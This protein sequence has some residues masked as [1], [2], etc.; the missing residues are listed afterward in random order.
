MVML[1]KD[2]DFKKIE[3]RWQAF[4]DQNKT[5]RAVDNSNQPTFYVL[6]MLPY[7]S[8]AGL[9][10]GH[11]EGYTATDILGRMK[12]SQGYNVL[13]PMGWDAFGLPAEQ[14]A[15]A[16]GIHP[17]QNTA[18][19][20]QHFKKQLKSIG[21]GFDWDR[22]VNS[23]D[24]GFYK[25]TQ[26]IFLQLFKAGLAY[27]DEKPVWWCDALGTV[28]ANEEIING[29]SERGNHPV[30]RR[31]LRQWVLRITDYADKLLEGLDELD[32]PESTVRLQ[33]AWIGKSEGAHIRFALERHVDLYIEAFTTRSD[34]LLGSTY[35]V[36]APEHPLLPKLATQNNQEA[37]KV[38]VEQAASK[39]DLDRTELAKDKTGVFTGSYAV[40]PIS[41]AKM[42][43]WVSDYVLMSYGTG[44]VMAVPGHDERDFEFAEK[45]NLPVVCVVSEQQG[46][47][48][49]DDL[50]YTADG[51]LVNSGCYDGLSC[52]KARQ[53]ITEDLAQKG[54]GQKAVNYKLRDWLFSRQRYWGEPFPVIWVQQADYQRCL[55]I[56][57]SPFR[58]YLPK[59]PVSYKAKDGVTYCALALPTKALPLTLPEVDD[60]KPSGTG[61]S[62][63]AKNLDW[64][65]VA[66]NLRTAQIVPA[67]EQAKAQGD[68]VLGL[69]E[70]NTMPQWAGSCWYYLRY[71][72]PHNNERFIGL[73]KEGY[74]GVPDLYVGGAEHAVLHLLYARFWHRA[75]YDLG[76][77]KTKEP[78]PKLVHQGMLLGELEFTGYKNASGDPV[79][80]KHV[81]SH[82]TDLRHG[83]VLTP[84]K[85][86]EHEVEK[87]GDAFYLRGY[88]DVV[89]D[90]RAYKMSKSRGNVV[91]PETVMDEHGADALRMYEMFLGPIEA[92][93]PW[94]TQGI[95][96]ISRFLRK[97]WKE[98]IN[99]QGGISSK[100]VKD[101]QEDSGTTKILH[102]TIKKVT[103]DIEAMR[104]N[105]A[106]SQMMIFI[107]HIQKADTFTENTA[108][109]FLQLLAP[110]APHI[111]EE[112]WSRL[113]QPPSI[114]DAPW[115]KYEEVHLVEDTLKTM[116]QVNGKVRA[117]VLLSKDVSKE[118][119]LNRARNLDRVSIYLDGK[120]LIK[121]VYVPGRII[122]FVVK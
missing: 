37:I 122:N 110:Y 30:V 70:T 97:I 102:E 14:H 108:K 11:P 83:D 78:F 99:T 96:G 22:E 75:L 1:C 69:R 79:S 82:D 106:I 95:E 94:N 80:L 87:R 59:E 71:L 61:E 28:L 72:D 57:E 107:N 100:I 121:E 89:I 86:Q 9:H 56:K 117:E 68:W 17:A 43:I 40:H 113:G 6:D 73:D 2:Y 19:N 119:A 112:L 104:F 44:A 25:W 38:Y 21:F 7:P 41:G 118:E 67:K 32:W 29:R 27:V 93:K 98:Y 58:E 64:L 91:S 42:P 63:L 85:L 116:V 47:T 33:R 16:T 34:T 77:L 12:K 18:K 24:P 36:I 81:S 35:I 115:P 48:S 4:W 23:T 66:L 76:L 3:A 84:F 8:G 92:S 51:Y 111:C 50:P 46:D 105:T 26:W 45:F 39:S 120:T 54:M 31:N 88:Q 15:I 55:Q 74:W 49:D 62:P 52:E 109:I 114:V 103:Q 5:F 10:I 101:V 20:I 60:Y 53:V 13:H 65:Q 90:A